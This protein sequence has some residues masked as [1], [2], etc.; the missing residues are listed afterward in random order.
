MSFSS[1]ASSWSRPTKEVVST[2]RP[3]VIEGSNRQEVM[4]EAVYD[5]LENPLGTSQVP[6]AVLTQIS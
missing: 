1:S 6:K 2:G 5:E 3:G 4:G